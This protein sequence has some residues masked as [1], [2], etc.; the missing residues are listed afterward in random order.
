MEHIISKLAVEI[1]NG[2]RA[3]RAIMFMFTQEVLSGPAGVSRARVTASPWSAFGKVLGMKAP[4]GFWDP[5][6]LATGG[7]IENSAHRR[8]TEIKHGRF[9]MLSALK[10]AG[11]GQGPPA[12]GL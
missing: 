5:I 10:R 2:R 6:G 3:R 7:S 9:G 12:A 11:C 1:T 8:Q 4:V